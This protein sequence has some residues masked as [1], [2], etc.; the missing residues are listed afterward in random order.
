MGPAALISAPGSKHLKPF[1]KI[2][3]HVTRFQ[4]LFAAI[5]AL[6]VRASVIGQAI[7]YFELIF[8]ALDLISAELKPL[9]EQTGFK[10]TLLLA[11]TPCTRRKNF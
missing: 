9:Q 4:G 6:P 11:Q 3:I 8:F 10:K 7:F 2:E 1:S 5:S